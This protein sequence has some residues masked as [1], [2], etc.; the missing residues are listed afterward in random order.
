MPL[1]IF[2]FTFTEKRI[3]E[4]V[5]LSLCVKEGGSNK[6]N[7]LFFIFRRKYRVSKTRFKLSIQ[8]ILWSEKP[9]IIE[10]HKQSKNS[11]KKKMSE[12]FHAQVYYFT[13]YSPYFQRSHPWRS[14]RSWWL[15]SKEHLE[16]FISSKSSIL[17]G[18]LTHCFPVR[19][20]NLIISFQSKLITL[21]PFEKFSSLL[22]IHVC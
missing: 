4:N 19:I 3:I 12:T 20:Q 7:Y 21:L 14:V 2:G 16:V 1:W 6:A 11:W 22:M 17:V 9:Q 10:K 18:I 8:K 5:S 15:W 13:F